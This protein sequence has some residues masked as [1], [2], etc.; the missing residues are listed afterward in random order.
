MFRQWCRSSCY[1]SRVHCRRLC[2]LCFLRRQ[3]SQ[4]TVIGSPGNPI[5]NQDFNMLVTNPRKQR[6]YIQVNDSLGFAD[7]TT[8]TGEG[9]VCCNQDSVCVSRLSVTESSSGS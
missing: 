1:S 3:N 4:T 9:E 2:W 6:L 7:L 8:G 5:W